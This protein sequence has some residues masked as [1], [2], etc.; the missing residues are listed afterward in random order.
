MLIALFIQGLIE[1]F[2]PA[3][4]I[5]ALAGGDGLKGILSALIIGIPLPVNGLT[6]VPIVKGLIHSGMGAAP[7]VTFLM[8]GPV[9]SI[10][11]MVALLGMFKKRVF[12]IYMAAGITGSLMMGMF[13]LLFV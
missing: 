4:W 11:A 12:V 8:A 13:W 10:P 9:T 1:S 5:L 6:A 7:A 3:N 2:V